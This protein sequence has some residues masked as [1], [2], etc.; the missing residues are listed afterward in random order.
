MQF[1][2]VVRTVLLTSSFAKEFN[3]QRII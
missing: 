1:H 2:F 3:V